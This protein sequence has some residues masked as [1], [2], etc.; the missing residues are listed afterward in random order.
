M[1]LDVCLGTRT[2]WKILFVLGEAP[3]KAVSRKEIHGL[4]GLGSKVIAKFLL[5]LEKF[6]VVIS[7]KIGRT[8]YYKLNLSNRFTEHILTIID[9]EKKNLNN[10]DFFAL[11]V[12]R[13]FVYELT[14]TNLENIN[15]IILFGSYAKR[16]YGKN[17]D[18][19]VAIILD[20]KKPA[21]ELLITEIIDKLEKRFKKE[22]QPHYYTTKEFE[23]LKKTHDRLVE[24][25]AKDGIV[26]M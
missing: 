12:L 20:E 15:K 2:A 22:I 26:L 18:I 7:S 14:N 3:G 25:I 4:T 6:D 1:L 21:D 17:S 11:N 9:L 5:M 19:D 16:T 10:P 23:K 13:E 24:E 8:H